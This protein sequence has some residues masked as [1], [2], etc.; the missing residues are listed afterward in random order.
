MLMIG[1]AV[2][3]AAGVFLLARL[4]GGKAERLAS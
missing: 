1:A 3:L 2:Y 4:L